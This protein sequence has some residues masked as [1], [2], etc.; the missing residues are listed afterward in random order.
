MGS[1]FL[2]V[3][4]YKFLQK[5]EIKFKE[6][7]FNPSSIVQIAISSEGGGAGFSPIG[8]YNILIKN[9]IDSKSFEETSL[10]KETPIKDFIENNIG[11]LFE[12]I[13]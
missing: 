9:D 6:I 13:C 12:K 3:K 2:G 4:V 11:V 1:T 5:E 7:S 8:I 10:D